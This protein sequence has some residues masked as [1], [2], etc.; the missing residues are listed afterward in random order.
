VSDL[1]KLHSVITKVD[2][3]VRDLN[4]IELDYVLA[5]VRALNLKRQMFPTEKA[6]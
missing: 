3:A 4:W 6:S 2:Q 5:K 1:A